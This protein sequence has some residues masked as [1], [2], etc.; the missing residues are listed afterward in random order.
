[1]FIKVYQCGFDRTKDSID[2]ASDSYEYFGWLDPSKPKEFYT[3]YFTETTDLMMPQ[4]Q[5]MAFDKMSQDIEIATVPRD[6][7]DRKRH[8]M[9]QGIVTGHTR[10]LRFYF[11]TV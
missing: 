1:M 6:N 3:E 2:V 4:K 10:T 5:K 11:L 8:L 9:C 7:Q